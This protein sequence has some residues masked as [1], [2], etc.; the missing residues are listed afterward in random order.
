MKTDPI[1]CKMCKE[2]KARSQFQ[3]PGSVRIHSQRVCQPCQ[4]IVLQ[5][6]LDMDAKR[7]QRMAAEKVKTQWE[8]LASTVCEMYDDGFTFEAI[9]RKLQREAERIGSR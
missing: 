2:V 4:A 8:R 7:E 3:L 9:G 6:R 1:P 5:K